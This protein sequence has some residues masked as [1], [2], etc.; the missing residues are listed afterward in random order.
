MMWGRGEH[1][2][3]KISLLE[4]MRMPGTERPAP[5]EALAFAPPSERLA[6]VIAPPAEPARLLP[7]VPPKTDRVGEVA[8]LLRT[9]A[10]QEFCDFAAEVGAEPGAVWAWAKGR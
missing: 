1:Q 6:P 7:P 4:A 3:S 9:M 2:M 8:A 10:Y 5:T